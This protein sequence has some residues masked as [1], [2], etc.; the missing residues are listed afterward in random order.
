MVHELNN[1]HTKHWIHLNIIPSSR[2]YIINKIHEAKFSVNSMSVSEVARRVAHTDPMRTCFH[3][4]PRQILIRCSQFSGSKASCSLKV[5][6]QQ[7]WLL[8]QRMQCV[9]TKPKCS[10]STLSCPSS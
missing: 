10:I 2:A 4:N 5:V 1:I 9:T 7:N 6:W 3:R 8:V